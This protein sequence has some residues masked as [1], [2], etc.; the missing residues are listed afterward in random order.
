MDVEE[1]ASALLAVAAQAAATRR[2][3][4]FDVIQVLSRVSACLSIVGS[5]FVLQS[6][7]R[8]VLLHRPLAATDHLIFVYLSLTFGVS[9]AIALGRVFLPEAVCSVS[10]CPAPSTACIMQASIIQFCAM[11]GILWVLAGNVLLLTALC[12]GRALLPGPPTTWTAGVPL[13]VVCVVSL[14][15]TCIIG[16]SGGFGDADLYCWIRSDRARRRTRARLHAPASRL[17]E[18]PPRTRSR[19]RLR[20]HS[21]SSAYHPRT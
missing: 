19:T 7:L 1:A 4:E 12:T 11:S 15:A 16:L 10:P 5:L 14:V 21:H 20:T 17:P 18:A 13:L 9:T 2:R 6:L 3:E 8:Q